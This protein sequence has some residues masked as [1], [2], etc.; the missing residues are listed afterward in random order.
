M[1]VLR[2]NKDALVTILE[3]FLRNPLYKWA[4]P[5]S[6]AAAAATTTAAAGGAGAD[7]GGNHRAERTLLRVQQKL[8]GRVAGNSELLSV[9]GQVS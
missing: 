4:Q 1:R 8:D 5:P 3:V 6:S 7:E 9:Q 2:Q